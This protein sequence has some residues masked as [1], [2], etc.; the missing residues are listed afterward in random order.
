M[1]VWIPCALRNLLKFLRTGVE[2]DSY[3]EAENEV[4]VD[5]Y[6]I[7]GKGYANPGHILSF[8]SDKGEMSHED[9][10]NYEDICRTPHILIAGLL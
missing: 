5:D 8:I 2:D 10:A 4:Y 3:D 7:P 1:G 9:E 6:L